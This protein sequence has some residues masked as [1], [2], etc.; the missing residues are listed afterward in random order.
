MAKKKK[1]KSAASL[2]KWAKRTHT[3]DIVRQTAKHFKPI[4]RARAVAVG[5]R[6]KS[7][8]I[9]ISQLA[10]KGRKKKKKK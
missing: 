6:A 5:L 10:K 1:K 2:L 9:S 3:K 7:L 8:G 4:K